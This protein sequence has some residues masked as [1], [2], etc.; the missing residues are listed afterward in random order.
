MS[1]WNDVI[2]VLNHD[3][4]IRSWTPLPGT[5]H[6]AQATITTPEHGE[7]AM[8]LDNG[9]NK[10]W[11]QLL[12]TVSDSTAARVWE[13]AGRSLQDTPAIGLAQ[14]GESIV[15]RHGILLPHATPHAITNGIT[16]TIT[17]ATTLFDTTTNNQP[18]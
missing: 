7:I 8:I 11:L 6:A 4:A 15:I 17:A 13:A 16:L 2:T 5:T 3:P 9:T 1:D 10:H 18:V 12:I 14:Y